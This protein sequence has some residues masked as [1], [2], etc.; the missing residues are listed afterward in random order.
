MV[1]KFSATFKHLEISSHVLVVPHGF[2]LEEILLLNGD[3]SIT[4]KQ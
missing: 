2:I 1:E 3:C 4:N